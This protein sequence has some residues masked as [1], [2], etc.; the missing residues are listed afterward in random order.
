[1]D[2]YVSLKHVEGFKSVENLY[3]RYVHLLVCTND[4]KHSA[5][6]K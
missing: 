1:M 2:I 5:R 6:T 4:Y 3:F